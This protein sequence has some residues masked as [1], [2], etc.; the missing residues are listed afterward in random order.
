MMNVFA[1]GVRRVE[2]EYVVCVD[3]L[4]NAKWLLS[5]LARS[6]VYG[7]ARPIGEET[8]SALYTFRVPVDARLPLSG[9]NNLL[10]AIPE[11]LLLSK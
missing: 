9:L 6:F 8:G 1:V 3:G 5:Q 7:S 2:H 4:A 10:T 11:V